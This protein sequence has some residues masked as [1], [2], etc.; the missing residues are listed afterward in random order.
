LVS[1][2]QAVELLGIDFPTIQEELKSC[3]AMPFLIINIAP[4]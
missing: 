2:L 1:S 4:F 3:V